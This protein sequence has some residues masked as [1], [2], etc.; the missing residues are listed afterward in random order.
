MASSF[1]NRSPHLLRLRD[2]LQEA[3][4]SVTSHTTSILKIKS[5]QDKLQSAPAALGGY[6]SFSRLFSLTQTLILK[7][8]FPPLPPMNV[9]ISCKTV[10]KVAKIN[11]KTS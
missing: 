3:L 9:K 8:H 11:V 10:R 7:Q 2:K 1:R 5:Q 4:H 6:Q